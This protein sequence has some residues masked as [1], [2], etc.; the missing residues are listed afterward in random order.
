MEPE[1]TVLATEL[2]ERG[3]DDRDLGRAAG[4]GARDKVRALDEE[5]RYACPLKEG[6]EDDEDDDEL[7]ADVYRRGEDAVDAVKQRV[8]KAVEV[9][10]GDEGVYD[11]RAGDEQNRKAHAAAAE[12]HDGEDADEADDRVE[13][14]HARCALDRDG[15]DVVGEAVVEERARAERHDDD[16]VPG[17]GVHLD[18]LLGDGVGDEAEDYH[19]AHEEGEPLLDAPVGKEGGPDA[20][21]GEGGHQ[22]VYH[23][24][25]LALPDAGVGL[26]VILA[27]DGLDVLHRSDVGAGIRGPVLLRLVGRA[28]EVLYVGLLVV[29]LDRSL[30]VEHLRV[31]QP[32]GLLF[33]LVR[34]YI[35]P[36]R[37]PRRPAG[38]RGLTLILAYAA[39]AQAVGT[40]M[41]FSAKYLAAPG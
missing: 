8:D 9:D 10:A 21:E 19:A 1:P 41:P 6:A 39:A 17:Q 35:P 30:G 36:G 28:V 18:V 22:C 32:V 14:G 16:V 31:E 13:R 37:K 25:G 20:V 4:G 7:R 38:R 34:H 3:G 11:Q 29:G 26:L 15:E 24:L 27:H 23:E 12:L 40:S 2:P 33:L 5:V